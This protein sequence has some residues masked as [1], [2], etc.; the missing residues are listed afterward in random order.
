MA[1]IS[2]SVLAPALPRLPPT[3]SSM[4]ARPATRATAMRQSSRS[5]STSAPSSAVSTGEMK[6]SAMASASGRRAS[7]KKNDVAMTTISSAR[8]L[9]WMVV[10]R[11]GQPGRTQAT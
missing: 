8:R 1:P 5:P 6:E 2:T 11:V 7:A 4:P 3:I 10:S 9:L